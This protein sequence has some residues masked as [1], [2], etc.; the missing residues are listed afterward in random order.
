[1]EIF[2]FPAANIQ[3]IEISLGEGNDHAHIAGNIALPVVMDGGA[4]NDHLKAGRGP[5]TLLEGDGNDLL[6]G[7]PGNDTLVGANGND[8]L[9]G[10]PGTDTLD[11]GVAAPMW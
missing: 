3:R 4:G 1:M 11:G 5:A 9:V 6:I 7:G 10:G 8:I 2:T